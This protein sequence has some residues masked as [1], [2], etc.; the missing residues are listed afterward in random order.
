MS[1]WIDVFAIIIL[2]ACVYRGYKKGIVYVAF[3]LVAFIVSILVALILYRPATEY[4]INNTEIDEK[5]ESVITSKEN[6]E[7]GSQSDEKEQNISS[8]LVNKS[9]QAITKTASKPIAETI[10]KIGVIIVLFIG[11]RIILFIVK[12][13]ILSERIQFSM[14]YLLFL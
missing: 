7:T 13:P 10:V 3:K 14:V 11:T 4:I 8:D 5:I 6:N 2:I 12:C 9:K 1:I